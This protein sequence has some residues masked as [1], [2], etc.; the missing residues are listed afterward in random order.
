MN[1][2]PTEKVKASRINPRR[3]LLYGKPKC[4]KTTIL[5]KLDN[6][7]LLDL[8]SG[9]DHVDALKMNIIGLTAPASEIDAI[10]SKR[11]ASQKFYLTEVDSMIKNY[12]KDNNGEFPYKY[13]AIDTITQLELWCEEHAT[14]MY[15]DSVQGKKFNRDE[16][17]ALLPKAKQESVLTLAQGAGYL[18]L[19]NAFDYWLNII[20]QLAPNII[21]IGHLKEKLINKSGKELT[22]LDLDLTGKISSLTAARCD[23]IGY[24]YRLKDETKINFASQ[25]A[26]CGSRV[27]HLLGQDVVIMTEDS[28]NKTK[29]THWETIYLPEN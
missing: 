22:S 23:A 17:G 24:V 15:M 18:W 16:S 12:R 6:C 5:S 27:E 13:V 8:E 11:H 7:L 4:G 29:T 1:Y 2:L 9:S 3:L 25:D 20:D 26:A 19:R 10:K 14:K 21:L 28:K